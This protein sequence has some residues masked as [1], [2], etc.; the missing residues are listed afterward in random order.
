MLFCHA[1]RHSGAGFHIRFC[2]AD[3]SWYAE[4]MTNWASFTTAFSTIACWIV[5]T[6]VAVE[7]GTIRHKQPW[8]QDKREGRSASLTDIR[9]AAKQYGG[10]EIYADPFWISDMEAERIW[11]KAT[12]R[13]AGSIH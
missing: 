5:G 3:V 11:Q 7:F 10:L 8:I 13:S 12:R 4:V 6:L 9:E 1:G 2:L